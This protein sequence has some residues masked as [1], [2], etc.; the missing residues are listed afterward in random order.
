MKLALHA[1]ACAACAIAL[2]TAAAAEDG[3]YVSGSGAATFLQ[4]SDNEGVFNGPFTTGAGTTIPAGT[5]LPD[6][7]TVG[8]TTEF[9][10]GYAINGAIGRAFG[11]F[12]GE[13]EVSYQDNGVDFHRDVTV[14]GGPIGTEDAGVLVTGSPNL[15]V[16]VADLVNDGEGGLDTIYVFAN[17][18]YDFNLGGPLKPY[19]GGGVGVGFVDV[20]Y[21][22]S[23]VSIIDDRATAFAWQAAAGVAWEV[24][25]SLDLFAGYRYRATSD[26]EVQADLFAADFDIENRGSL[27]EAGLRFKF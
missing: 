13:V 17:A 18:F 8:W 16:T 1:F 5:V 11:P 15:G 22:P 7:T 19:V 24:S 20:L 25:P 26:V 3:Y 12:R 2:S 27:A 9:S 10:T 6:G 14:G 4:N 23:G 21:R